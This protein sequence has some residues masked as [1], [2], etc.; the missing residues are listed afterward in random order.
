MKLVRWLFSSAAPW[1]LRMLR[2]LL[3]AYLG[4]L[5]VLKVF[6]NRFVYP[7]SIAGDDWETPDD[8]KEITLETDGGVKIVGWY[9]AHSQPLDSMVFFHGNGGH[10]QHR[11]TLI[12][13]L[14]DRCQANVLAIDYRGY[15]KS[16]GSPSEAGLIKD[17]E[18][19]VDWLCKKDE[20]KPS[21]L[22]ICG[23]SL[24]GAVAVQMAVKHQ[25]KGLILQR[26]FTTLPDAARSGP[27]G[28]IAPVEWMMSNQFR[29]VDI[30]DQYQGPLLQSHGTADEVISFRLGQQ[31]HA[32]A[33]EPKEF[34]TDQGGG[35]NT[36]DG[37]PYYSVLVNFLRSVRNGK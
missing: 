19:A 9:A 27:I 32:R 30:I 37:A 12:R 36:D 14:R 31:L 25:P 4:L 18:A 13:Q 28:R 3:L 7:R 21:S 8:F 20:I 22:L 33:N 2:T 17:A 26:T 24:G 34:F 6:E 35:H 23:R 16:D 11:V 5:I 1:W 10:L 15:G 29:S